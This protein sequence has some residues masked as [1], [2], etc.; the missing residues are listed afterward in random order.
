MLLRYLV[1]IA[2]D[3]GDAAMKDTIQ[4]L[5]AWGQYSRNKCLPQGFICGV[6][7]IMARNV[8]G[9]VGL[10]PPNQDDIDFIQPVMTKMKQRKPEHYRVIE[11]YYIE[12]RHIRQIA[13]ALGKSSGWVSDMKGSAEAWI[14]GA[15]SSYVLIA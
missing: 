2:N 14:D 11:L 13:K 1:Q 4:L 3:T 7:V 12:R 6:A 15:L 5:E 9:V 8:G 10:P